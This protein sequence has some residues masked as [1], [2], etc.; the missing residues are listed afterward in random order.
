MK[1]YIGTSNKEK[2]ATAKRLFSELVSTDITMLGQNTS[3]GVADAPWGDDILRGA[4]N[5]VEQCAHV[6][7]A[8]Y[9]IGIESGLVKRGGIVFEETWAVVLASNSS[10]GIAYSSSLPIPKK[11]IDIME[12]QGVTHDKAMH[13]IDTLLDNVNARKNHDTW[14]TYTGGQI[15]RSI[16]FDEALRNAILQVNNIDA[17]LY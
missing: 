6:A 13:Q 2:I 16:S 3:S 4:R 15:A 11:V 10:Q 17:S 9:Y 8:D 1:A 7:D 12:S 14:H 5:R